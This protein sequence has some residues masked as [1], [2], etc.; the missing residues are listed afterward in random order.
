MV[1]YSQLMS[2]TVVKTLLSL[3][4]IKTSTENKSLHREL[5]YVEITGTGKCFWSTFPHRG[6]IGLKISTHSVFKSLSSLHYL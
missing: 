5:N 3:L 2:R 6:Q 4:Y 1:A